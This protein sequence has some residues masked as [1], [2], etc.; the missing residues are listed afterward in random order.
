M[1][2]SFLFNSFRPLSLSQDQRWLNPT[3]TAI[4]KYRWKVLIN[5]CEQFQFVTVITIQLVSVWKEVKGHGHPSRF[6]ADQPEEKRLTWIRAPF[7]STE[8]M[9]ATKPKAVLA[10][11]NWAVF[12]PDFDSLLIALFRRGKQQEG[13]RARQLLLRTALKL[14]R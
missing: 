10:R 6:S 1:N 4:I 12:A 3:H 14:S 13:I 7:R 8:W 5:D 11:R 9:S 2:E